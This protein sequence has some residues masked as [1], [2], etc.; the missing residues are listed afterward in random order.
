M[1]YVFNMFRNK[2]R[3]S[4][5]PARRNVVLLLG[6][7][8]SGKSTLINYLTNFFHGG[9]LL[10][11]RIAIP[12]GYYHAT[13]GGTNS[14]NSIDDQT[15]SKT[16]KCSTYHFDLEGQSFDFIDSPGLSD[17][18][19]V[20]H[21]DKNIECILESAEKIGTLSAAVIIINGTVVRATLNLLNTLT[22]LRGN[23]PDILIDNLIVVLTNCTQTSYNFDIKTLYP[24]KIKPE[25]VF[26]MDNSA[27]SRNPAQWRGNRRMEEEMQK[28]WKISMEE[29]QKMV[30]RITDLDEKSTGVFKELRKNREQ[31]KQEMHEILLEINKLQQ[32]QD[33]LENAQKQ[34]QAAI[35]DTERYSNFKQTQ[36]VEYTELVDA[37]YYSTICVVHSKDRVCHDHC[38]LPETEQPG[39]G[40]HINCYCMDGPRCR[41]C[42]CGHDQHYHARKKLGKRKETVEKI[43]DDV[44]REHD[45]ATARVHNSHNRVT[46]LADDLRLLENTLH[47][48]QEMIEKCC[49]ELQRICSAFNF[50][51]EMHGVVEALKTNARTLTSLKARQEA[52][53]MIR[54]VDELVKRLQSM[55]TDNSRHESANDYYRDFDAGLAKSRHGAH[56]NYPER[57]ERS[58]DEYST[59]NRAG[60][61]FDDPDFDSGFPRSRTSDAL[62]PRSL[63][64]SERH[65][66]DED[67]N[68][69]SASAARRV[70][71]NLSPQHVESTSGTDTRQS[72]RIPNACRHYNRATGCQMQDCKF[73]HVCG[74]CGNRDHTALQ[75]SPVPSRAAVTKTPAQTSTA[76]IRNACRHFNSRNGCNRKECGFSHICGYC[77]GKSH[78]AMDCRDQPSLKTPDL[79]QPKPIKSDTAERRASDVPCKYYNQQD[80][81]RYKVCAFSHKCSECGKLNHGAASCNERKPGSTNADPKKLFSPFVQ[82]VC[83]E[84]NY[85]KPCKTIPCTYRHL[86]GVCGHLHAAVQCRQNLIK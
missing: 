12:N 71:M 18:K 44:K 76:L 81:C 35:H 13:E 10:E 78:I 74:N 60:T 79:A 86:C 3:S 28:A 59:R 4:R 8:G 23:L 33:E 1:A 61:T 65:N 43:L 17:T 69:R 9:T 40:V 2:E 49:V 42:E 85:G 54:T 73:P 47:E 34:H 30:Y 25:N 31:I 32:T 66:D 6:E 14:E 57:L 37:E 38:S 45:D 51:D 77:G 75:C 67:I 50:A 84:Y 55:R 72:L 11:P 5:K 41:V 29:I 7:T 20:S 22:R 48:K 70:Q 19:G 46:K 63:N 62:R 15:K 82:G 53:N 24:W 21:D 83:F 80:G 52:D 56:G 26:I 27:L 36:E 68:V 39:T 16:S 64:R 58:V